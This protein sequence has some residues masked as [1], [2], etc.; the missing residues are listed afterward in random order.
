MVPSP[1]VDGALLM[2]S[3][4]MHVEPQTMYVEVVAPRIPWL[5]QWDTRLDEKETIKRLWQRNK[6]D[7]ARVRV[8]VTSLVLSLHGPKVKSARTHTLRCHR[9]I[10]IVPNEDHTLFSRTCHQSFVFHVNLGIVC[11]KSLW[12]TSAHAAKHSYLSTG[13]FGQSCQHRLIGN[14]GLY[15]MTRV[16]VRTNLGSWLLFKK[17]QPRNK[18]VACKLVALQVFKMSGIIGENTYNKKSA[19]GFSSG[20]TPQHLPLANRT[21]PEGTTRNHHNNTII[22]LTPGVMLCCPFGRQICFQC[23]RMLTCIGV[24]FNKTKP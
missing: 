22:N 23:G 14:F 20:R 1:S 19:C 11:A 24:L 13:Q 16:C 8:D 12:K 2:Q 4:T 17:N 7:A 6:C 21:L 10:S 9:P 18:Q 5:V 3:P 15:P